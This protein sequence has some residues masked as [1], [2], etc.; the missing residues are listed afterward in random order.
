MSMSRYETVRDD[1]WKLLWKDDRAFS[2]G[3]APIAKPVI[4]FFCKR[5]EG[6]PVVNINNTT[7]LTNNVEYD[8]VVDLDWV[9]ER[10]N[11]TI[12]YKKKW[13]DYN[14]YQLAALQEYV[15]FAKNGGYSKIIISKQEMAAILPNK[16]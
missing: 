4:S 15:D 7:P 16:K 12:Q 2:Q 13:N 9:E 1:G 14:I 5:K 6:D 8:K 10:L 3:E 11:K